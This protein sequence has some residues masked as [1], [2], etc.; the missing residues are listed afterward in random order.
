MFEP[1]FQNYPTLV[2][3]PKASCI[4]IWIYQTTVVR[5]LENQYL[6]QGRDEMSHSFDTLTPG[7]VS[8]NYLKKTCSFKEHYTVP[9]SK[10]PRFRQLSVCENK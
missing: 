1:T 3:F 6:K 2:I 10:N 8:A 5:L 9:T 4:L 7:K